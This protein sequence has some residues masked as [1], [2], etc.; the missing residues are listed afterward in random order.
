MS[1][2]SSSR[3]FLRKSAVMSAAAMGT[4]ASRESSGSLP[5]MWLL[6]GAA[7]LNFRLLGRS[8]RNDIWTFEVSDAGASAQRT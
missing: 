4:V 5:A 1:D 6:R 3:D 8:R 2:L 7:P